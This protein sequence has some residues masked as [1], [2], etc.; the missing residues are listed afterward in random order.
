MSTTERHLQSTPTGSL[1]ALI[2]T[3]DD[4]VG[5]PGL[6]ALY[7]ASEGLGRRVIV[8]PEGPRSSCGHSV[9]TGVEIPIEKLSDDRYAVGG[10]PADCVR[11]GLFCLEPQAAWVLSGINAGGNLGADIH[12][13]GTVAAVREAAL[14][15]RG[16]IAFSHYLARGRAVDWE[17]AARWAAR[18]LELLLDR[19]WEPGTFWNVNLPHPSPGTPEPRIISCVVD[20]SPLPLAFQLG[21]DA[22][23]VRYAG[24]YHARPRVPAGDV[25]VCFGGDIS[26]SRVRLLPIDPDPPDLRR[27][28]RS[29]LAEPG[30]PDA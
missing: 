13:S 8:A 14:H 7:R 3:N 5:E 9:T 23:R 30:H 10:T 26:V 11:I 2:L 12:H 29:A 21:E 15:G 6:G 18:V 1:P 25:E 4:G 28:A 22:R 27:G 16:G 24:D 20:P 19:P 17:Q